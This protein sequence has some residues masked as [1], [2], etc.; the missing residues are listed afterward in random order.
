MANIPNIVWV[1][2]F[3]PYI[4]PPFSIPNAFARIRV[5]RQEP[6]PAQPD[7]APE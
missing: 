6:F 3:Q 4:G 1:P 7:Q 2:S 5:P